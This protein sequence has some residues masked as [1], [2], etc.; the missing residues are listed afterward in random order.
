MDVN[1]HL[2]AP[3]AEAGVLARIESRLQHLYKEFHTMA[4]E[5]DQLKAAVAAE[6]TVT[7]S[8]VA[9]LQGLKAKLDAAIAANAAGNPADLQALADSLAADTS[10]LAQAVTANTPADEAAAGPV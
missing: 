6:H 3:C 5:L 7:S 2:H 10:A 4:N 9:L 1:V 8:A